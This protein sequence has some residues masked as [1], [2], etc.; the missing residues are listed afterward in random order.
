M[1]A[2][3]PTHAMVL[4][5]GLGLRMRPLTET[6]PKPLIEVAGAT[7]LDRA[8]DRLVA[9][10]VET[11]VV[12]THWLPEQVEAAA[13]R[14]KAPA[15]EISREDVLLETGG[16]IAKALPKL[17][18]EA[19]YAINADIVWRDGAIPAL[20]RLAAAWRDDEMDGLLLLQSTV[21]AT[22]YSGDG[23]FLMDPMG[24]IARRPERVI[25]PFVFTGIQILHPRLFEGAAVE[26]FSL[27]RLYDAAIERERLFGVAHD[28]DWFHV[29]TPHAI[30]E[31]EAE[32]LESEGS[33]VRRL[34]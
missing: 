30:A 17:G 34:F 13:A 15:I 10:G 5:A 32:I 26:P 11:A 3:K 28:G 7:M 18:A 4:A 31:A 24:R 29:G 14:R 9:A 33:R 23:D 21:R 27:N 19:F 16:G 8:L 22:G 20:D 1:T 6:K 25:A 2:A 12:N